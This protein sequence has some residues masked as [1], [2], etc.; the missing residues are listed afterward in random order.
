MGPFCGAADTPVF[1][2]W[3]RLLWVS[4]S[5]WVVLFMLGRG[6]HVTHSL[7]FTSGVTP[8]NLLVTSMAAKP[9]LPHTPEALVG[10]KTGSYHATAHSVRSG[11]PDALLTE[12]SRLGLIYYIFFT[13]VVVVGKKEQVC[14]SY[15]FQYS[16][17]GCARSAVFRDSLSSVTSLWSEY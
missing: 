3:W 10:L 15:R 13:S 5:E 12:L 4:K 17:L 9:S 1:D 8:A 6:I 11:R 7:R 14:C 16:V 2:F